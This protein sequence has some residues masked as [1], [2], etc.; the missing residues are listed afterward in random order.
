MFAGGAVNMHIHGSSLDAKLYLP[1]ISVSLGLAP[2][3]QVIF[4]EVRGQVSESLAH[5][6]SCWAKHDLFKNILPLAN[7][8]YLILFS[9][10][11]YLGTGKP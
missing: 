3:P 6:R 8:G 10:P 4:L 1:V 11:F 7:S 2:V 5:F 9:F